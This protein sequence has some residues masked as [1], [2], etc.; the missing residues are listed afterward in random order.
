MDPTTTIAR[1]EMSRA[2]CM[3]LHNSMAFYVLCGNCDVANL[4]VRLEAMTPSRMLT[5]EPNPTTPHRN[6]AQHRKT[7]TMNPRSHYILWKENTRMLPIRQSY[8]Q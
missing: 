7:K 1:T 8:W 4:V 6:S 2:S 5:L 3:F